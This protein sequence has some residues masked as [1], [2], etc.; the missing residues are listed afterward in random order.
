MKDA[1]VVLILIILGSSKVNDPNVDGPRK[2]IRTLDKI[3]LWTIMVNFTFILDQ[4]LRSE[5]WKG[6]MLT[7]LRSHISL[8]ILL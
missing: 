3:L 8:D 1:R 6:A 2:L 7:N 5:A 4:F